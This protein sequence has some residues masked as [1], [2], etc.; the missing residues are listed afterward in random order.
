[1]Q[2]FGLGILP[3]TAHYHLAVLDRETGAQGQLPIEL[4]LWALDQHLLAVDLNLH[5]GRN[6]NRLFSNA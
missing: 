2:G 5:L 4:A 6:G 1:M 3:L